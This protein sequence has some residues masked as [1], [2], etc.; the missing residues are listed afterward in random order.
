M[1]SKP[2]RPVPDPPVPD[3]PVPD[4]AV[5]DPAVSDPRVPPGRLAGGV[6]RVSDREATVVTF[7]YL[8]AIFLGPVIP[9]IVYLI[10]SRR[11]P[12]ERQHAA[13]AANLSISGLVYALCAAIIGSLLALNNITTALVIGL[14]LVFV[15]WLTMVR[16]LIGGA[17]AANRGEQNEV[18]SWICAR[19]VR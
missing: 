19:I 14:S 12:F 18:P 16:Y 4:P 15:S 8:A 1:T 5:S 17:L 11:S 6:Q 7:G 13:T 2:A 3:P 10:V 9:L